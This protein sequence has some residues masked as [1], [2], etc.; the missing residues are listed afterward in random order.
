MNVIGLSLFASWLNLVLYALELAMVVLYFRA[1]P[2]DTKFIRIMVLT[3]ITVDTVGTLSVC[4]ATWLFVIT[5]ANTPITQQLWPT[6]VVIVATAICAMLEQSFLIYRFF[7]LSR[8]QVISGLLMLLVVT[9]VAFAILS[10]VE[11]VVHPE[12]KEG[13]GTTATTISFCIKAGLNI[14]IPIFLIWQLYKFSSPF[15][16]TK[17]LIRRLTAHAIACGTLVAV[18]GI[19]FLILFW[20]HVP[21]F[22]VI[23][24]IFG[25][26]YSLTVLF[27][28]LSRRARG[29]RN[30][31]PR[32][33]NTGADRSF[34]VPGLF[35][36]DLTSPSR[37]MAD[38]VDVDDANHSSRSTVP[39]ASHSSD[40]LK[41]QLSLTEPL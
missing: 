41:G 19:L 31:T 7:S 15:Q 29:T 2:R 9:H 13:L 28:L 36:L 5:F 14:C 34:N 37:I 33:M 27:N 10:A 18:T 4:A 24:N 25:R 17:S 30:N 16:S 1:F 32:S 35:S 20:R 40:Q 26:L 23:S 39:N 21:E 11:T 6:P 12:F 22:L 38:S 8:S 3:A